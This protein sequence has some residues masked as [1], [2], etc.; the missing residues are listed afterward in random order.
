MADLILYLF[1]DTNL[2]IQCR[3]L[4]ELGWAPERVND[5]LAWRRRAIS[6]QAKRKKA[7]NSLKLPSFGA[8]LNGLLCVAVRV[9]CG[10]KL[11]V[12]QIGRFLV[13]EWAGSP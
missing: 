3:P 6:A 2:F 1:P 10:G 12:L 9:R 13:N 8:A 5:Y 11:E 7:W 4:P